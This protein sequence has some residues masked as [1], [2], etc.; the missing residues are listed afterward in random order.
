VIRVRAER[1]LDEVLGARRV[2]AQ[3]SDGAE[4]QQRIGVVR[5]QLQRLREL[6]LGLVELAGV[7]ERATEVVVDLGR[8][9]VRFAVGALLHVAERLERRDVRC[10]LRVAALF[11][12]D[13]RLR[14][15]LARLVAGDVLERVR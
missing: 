4:V 7:R 9:R 8:R 14:R 6:G 3:G 1:L 10:E 13:G 15:R 12:R 11:R 2:A 5:I